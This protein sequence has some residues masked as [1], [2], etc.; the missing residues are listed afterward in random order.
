MGRGTHI[1]TS[2]MGEGAFTFGNASL[3]HREFPCKTG[4]NPA[5]GQPKEN[6]MNKPRLTEEERLQIENGLRAG[7]TPYA[8]AKALARPVR[9]VVR[10]IRA[11]RT[12]S[13]KGAYGR[14]T[15]RCALRMQ[16]QRHRICAHCLYDGNRACH[17]CRLCNERCGAFVEEKCPRLER[18]PWVCNGCKNE[19]RCTLRKMYYLHSCAQKNYRDLL[20]ESR[21]GANVSEGELAAFD[22]TLRDLTAK[23]QSVHAAMANNPGLFPVCEKTVYRYI[24]GGLLSTKNGDLPRKMALKPRKGKSVEH[25]VDTQCRIGRTYA[26]YQHFLADNPGCPV[27]EMDTVEGTKGGKV[28]LTLQF[29]PWGFMLAFLLGRKRSAD[30]LAAFAD[31][32]RR[33]AAAFGPEA[34]RGLYRRLFR[35]ILTD[36]GSEFSD[37]HPIETGRDGEPLARL[38][39][40]DPC[41]SWQKAHVERN[42]ELLRLV[43]P[44]ATAYAQATSFDA[45]TQVD[46]DRLLSH[47]N[48][49]VRPS[50]GDQTPLALFAREYGD[51][52]ASLFGVEEIAPNDVCLKP[53]L[54]GIDVK[55]KPGITAAGNDSSPTA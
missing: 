16:C 36:N 38:F 5:S 11:R 18:S 3:H 55:L 47:V 40:C 41:K 32:R 4:G 33:L 52:L 50:L 30:V 45:L 22:Q 2:P 35:C 8:I 53:S 34:A 49:Y 44:K 26:D 20:V 43:L 31:I 48:S 54:L 14:V 46:I 17:H 6:P 25:K 15:N 28:L 23:G 24:A 10:E 21:T 51:R 19:P 7:K 13:E 27:T 1:P 42:H 12:P 39:Y 37:P 9:T 29:M